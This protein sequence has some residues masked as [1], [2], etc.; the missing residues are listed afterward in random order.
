MGVVVENGEVWWEAIGAG[1]FGQ[2]A[3][4]AGWVVVDGVDVDV[5]AGA[6][7]VVVFRPGLRAEVWVVVERGYLNGGRADGALEELHV[8]DACGVGSFGGHVGPLVTILVFDLVEDDV[9]SVG[10][11]VRVNDFGHLLHVWLPCS[12]VSRVVVAKGAIIAGSEPARESTC[13]GFGVD[14]RTRTEDHI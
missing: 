11:R 7:G 14:I 1:A 4:P 6:D 8:I 5:A 12:G 3:G 10:D 13:V 9:A 2:V